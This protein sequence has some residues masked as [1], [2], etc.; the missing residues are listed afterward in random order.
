MRLPAMAVV[1]EGEERKKVEQFLL[2]Y[3]VRCSQP[4]VWASG[5][6]SQGGFWARVWRAGHK[7][8]ESNSEPPFSLPN[9]VRVVSAWASRALMAVRCGVGRKA[10]TSWTTS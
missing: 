3:E 9:S 1:S 10:S 5:V 2:Q 8:H 4:R 6:R 7:A